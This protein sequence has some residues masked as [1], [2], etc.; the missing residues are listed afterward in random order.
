MVVGINECQAIG[1]V[2]DNVAVLPRESAEQGIE[3]S[4]VLLVVDVERYPIP[5]LL[6]L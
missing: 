6:Q 3:I 2:G 1:V 4:E 5:T